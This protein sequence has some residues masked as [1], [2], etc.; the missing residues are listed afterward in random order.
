MSTLTGLEAVLHLGL[1]NPTD[2]GPSGS[3][4]GADRPPRQTGLPLERRLPRGPPWPAWQPAP[5]PGRVQRR[6]AAGRS[7]ARAGH[8]YARDYDRTLGQRCLWFTVRWVV[9]PGLPE[10][11]RAVLR[12]ML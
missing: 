1:S 7:P 5:G 12:V 11:H 2:S 4:E 6:P 3:P 10:A 8:G 9:V